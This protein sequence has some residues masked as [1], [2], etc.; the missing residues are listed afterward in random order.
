MIEK[1]A[2]LI[3]KT[4]II[5]FIKYFCKHFHEKTAILYIFIIRIFSLDFFRINGK[6]L[7]GNDKEKRMVKDILKS[8][9]K[10][11]HHKFSQQK[12]GVRLFI[13]HL[14]GYLYFAWA[15]ATLPGSIH[16]K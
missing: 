16:G 15:R 10:D 13:C 8:Y 3:E 14:P 7:P 4:I 11:I 6:V 9:L 5:L 2:S 12:H 1:S